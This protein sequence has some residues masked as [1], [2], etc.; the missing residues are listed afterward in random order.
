MYRMKCFITFGVLTLV[1]S[2]GGGAHAQTKTARGIATSSSQI[3]S[4]V[5]EVGN[6]ESQVTETTTL[7]Q[8]VEGCAQ[9]SR[10]YDPATDT[11][12]TADPVSVQFITAGGTQ[13]HIQRPDGS[14]A[15]YNLDGL[16]GAA[17]VVAAPSPVANCTAPWGGVVLH[18]AGVTAYQVASVTSPATCASQAE[19]RTCNDGVLSGSYPNQNCVV[20]V[21]P[22]N[23]TAPWGGAI[24]HGTSVL[25]YQTSSVTAP[26]TCRSET[27]TC[28]D[29]TLS[30]GFTNQNCVVNPS[31]CTWTSVMSNSAAFLCSPSISGRNCTTALGRVS[32]RCD[33]STSGD[34]CVVWDGVCDSGITDLYECRC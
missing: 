31:A 28:N 14:T 30:G 18:G 32:E 12:R 8:S 17:T 23:C 19:T 2:L 10:F 5:P 4:I 16:A 22:A 1:L 11:C 33:A 34:R 13:L 6:I 7:M 25:A 26:A 29:G 20:D 15:I 27:R 24:A 9:D 21:P 3:S